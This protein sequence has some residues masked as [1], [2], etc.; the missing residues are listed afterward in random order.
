MR[1]LFLRSSRSP[2]VLR[3]SA[4]ALSLLVALTS[5]AACAPPDAA[6]I[7]QG[8]GLPA[9]RLLDWGFPDNDHPVW[10][11]DGRWIAVSSQSPAG[12]DWH[13]QVVSPDGRERHDL[14]RWGCNDPSG[15]DYAWLPDD[16][17]A[18]IHADLPPDQLC[19][20]AAPFTSCN[21]VRLSAAVQTLGEGATW[22][23][24]GREPLLSA[25]AQD[26]DGSFETSPNLYVIT[27]SGQIAQTLSFQDQG[28]IW[29]PTWAP[30]AQ[31]LSYLDGYQAGEYPNPL[32]PLVESA[33]R[34]DAAG[35]LTL[36][37]PR[38][39]ANG[40]DSDNGQYA[41]SPSGHWVAVRVD[42]AGG[43]ASCSSTRPTR[44]R[45]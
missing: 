45:R 6:T 1:V 9:L 34:W 44:R 13:L 15:Y 43:T 12:Q 11:P 37:P 38:T 28:G 4:L 10:S 16:R 24:D 29:F 5:L 26:P 3:A 8:G 30:H 25:D 21:F 2:R 42:D 40:L 20:G 14:S 17:L 32:S 19:I 33:V 41:W 7:L 27:P 18:C 22:T 39:L 31:V 35:R 36:G 23:P